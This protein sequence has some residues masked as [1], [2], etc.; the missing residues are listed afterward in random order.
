MQT[1]TG[2][3]E[4]IPEGERPKEGMIALSEYENKML[5]GV[6][7]EQRMFKLSWM[8]FFRDK[9]V[10]TMEKLAMKRAFEAGWNSATYFKST[11]IN[12]ESF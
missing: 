4:R 5:E 11:H 1:D 3:I 8:R 9:K 7:E 10:P 12:T 2:K 6:P